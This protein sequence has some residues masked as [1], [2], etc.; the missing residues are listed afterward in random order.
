MPATGIAPGRPAAVA[1]A[2]PSPSH[3]AEHESA[4]MVTFVIVAAILLLIGVPLVV[5]NRDLLL[6]KLGARQHDVVGDEPLP[7][8]IIPATGSE[9]PL[10][11]P[12]P[13]GR[14]ESWAEPPALRRPDEF[15]PPAPRVAVSRAGGRFMDDDAVG[16]DAVIAA[17]ATLDAD[18]LESESLD[19]EDVDDEPLPAR[20]PSFNP[21]VDGATVVFR[22]PIDEPVQILP[23]RLE[24][25]A[26][27]P[28]RD[29]IRFV[30]RMGET[31]RITLGRAPGSAQRV[32]TLRSPTVSR[33]HARMEFVDGQWTITNLSK[34]NPVVV[35]EDMLAPD[36]SV[37]RVLAEGDRI[38]LG[39]VV[40]RFH[41]R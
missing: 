12:M 16:D 36:G 3:G 8:L 6:E 33:R 30:G 11:P 38:E 27:E 13:L 41:E 32:V 28:A 26:G 1:P 19:E 24:I 21:A 25:V 14:A 20:R 31:A 37:G 17:L 7:F 4:L 5:D 23:G 35:N 29:D 9:T 10:P 2:I 39:E 40:L 22:R 18:A 15:A 34:T